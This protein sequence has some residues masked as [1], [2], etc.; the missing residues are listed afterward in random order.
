[1]RINSIIKNV[2]IAFFALLACVAMVAAAYFAM[3]YDNRN[4][5]QPLDEDEYSIALTNGY[6]E[7][8]YESIDCIK[9]IESNLG[10]V[11]VSTDKTMQSQ[12]LGKVAVEAGNLSADVSSLPVQTGDSLFQVEK[13]CNQLQYYSISLI[14]RISAGNKLDGKDVATVNGVR[15]TALNLK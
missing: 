4:V 2:Y 3:T 7:K 10:K 14:Q 9:N 6:R 8:L 13:F 15:E 12:L 11:T 5:R 1:M